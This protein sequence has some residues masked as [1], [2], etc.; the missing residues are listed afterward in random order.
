KMEA[1]I[2]F[3]MGLVLF[4]L[5]IYVLTQLVWHVEVE[6]NE[7]IPY[8]DIIAVAEQQGIHPFQWKFKLD[9]PEVLSR[10]L[11]HSLP[12]AA[13]VGVE[14]KGTRIRIKVVEQTLPVPKQLM[15]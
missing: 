14:I 11:T 7:R 15:T 4:I 9:E 13:W 10:T 3:A 6:G 5:G 12:G 8:D 2:F 1:R